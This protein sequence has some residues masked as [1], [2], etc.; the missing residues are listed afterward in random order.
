MMM[1]LICSSVSTLLKNDLSQC[2]LYRFFQIKKFKQS[3][4][5]MERWMDEWMYKWIIRRWEGHGELS[6]ALTKIFSLY[7]FWRFG[8]KIHLLRTKKCVS[9]TNEWELYRHSF[10]AVAPK[11][12]CENR[13]KFLKKYIVYN[14]DKLLKVQHH[15]LSKVSSKWW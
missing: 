5:V 11:K 4:A 9:K 14:F 1:L 2:W 15:G 7:F 8:P 3:L 13:V 6:S 10:R 12:F